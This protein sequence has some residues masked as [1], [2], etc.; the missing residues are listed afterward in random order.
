MSGKQFGNS[1]YVDGAGCGCGGV[2]GGGV[3]GG[4]LVADLWPKV[5]LQHAMNPKSWTAHNVATVLMIIGVMCLL[6]YTFLPGTGP[7]WAYTAGVFA[8][9]YVV[10]DLMSVAERYKHFVDTSMQSFP[11]TETEIAGSNKLFAAA[12]NLASIGPAM[13]AAIAQAASG[14]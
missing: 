13:N 1:E 7:G 8:F 6:I 10:V 12:T 3:T 14:Q 2:D 11:A 9:I 4:G 5:G